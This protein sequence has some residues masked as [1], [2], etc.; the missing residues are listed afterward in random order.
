[1]LLFTYTKTGRALRAV[2][3]DKEMA[4]A[5]GVD[6]RRSIAQTF[7]LSF[8]V[9][10]IAGVLIGPLYFV[11]ADM[12]DMVGMKAFSAAVFGGINSIPGT[13]LGGVIIGLLETLTGGYVSSAY[14]DLVPF[15]ILLLM[16]IARPNGLLGP[17]NASQGLKGYAEFDDPLG[18]RAAARGP[19]RGAPLLGPYRNLHR[20]LHAAGDRA[21]F[22]HRV[23]QQNFVGARRGFRTRSLYDRASDDEI[24]M[25]AGRHIHTFD[26][27]CRCH[28]NRP[29]WAGHAPRRA[30]LRHGDDRD[31]SNR[32]DPPDEL[33]RPDQRPTGRAFDPTSWNWFCKSEAR[34]SRIIMRRSLRRLCPSLSLAAFL[35]AG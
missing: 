1:M 19:S 14:K 12:G 28:R 20:H 29:G 7:G 22:S 11:S 10:A 2:A 13:I 4:S 21:W 15:V 27:C 16:L 6:V 9:A 5:M 34:R 24:R 18:D 3:A 17:R 32:L 30:L 33:D 31:P 8:A 23:H 35:R 26:P 25:V